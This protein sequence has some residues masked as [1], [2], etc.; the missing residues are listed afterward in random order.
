MS[1]ASAP[2]PESAGPDPDNRPHV[3]PLRGAAVPTLAGL[4]ADAVAA[5][6]EHRGPP[7][8]GVTCD[9]DP[10]VT[11]DGDADALRRM[12]VTL[13]RRAVAAAS[14]ADPG[15]DV[16]PLREVV[17][18]AVRTAAAVEIEVADSGPSSIRAAGRWPCPR[19]HAAFRAGAPAELESLVARLGGAIEVRHC[20]EGGTAV[21]LLLPCRRSLGVAA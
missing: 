17:V 1:S 11:F 9:V 18:T 19:E 3:L 10:A 13:L 15:S 20:P 5:V 4:V 7:R 2:G 14:A 8:V 6:H 21:T 12:L 16:P